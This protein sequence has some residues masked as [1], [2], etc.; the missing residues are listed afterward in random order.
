[1]T[2]KIRG[3][4][5]HLQRDLKNCCDAQCMRCCCE[6]SPARRSRQ[7]YVGNA[8]RELPPRV[9]AR[10]F[11]ARLDSEQVDLPRVAP[12]RQEARVGGEGNGPRVNYNHRWSTR[13]LQSQMVHAS[14]TTTDGPRVNYNHRWPTCQLQP[15]MVH[16]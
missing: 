4:P 16:A 12:G 5:L 15:Q 8:E 7:T 9:E 6:P 10:L 2:Y 13:Q 14:T 3:S 11:L 1:M